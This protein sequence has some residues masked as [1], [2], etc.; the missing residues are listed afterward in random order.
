M[1]AR[2]FNASRR[3]TSS[4]SSRGSKSQKKINE[5]NSRNDNDYHSSNSSSDERDPTITVRM[6]STTSNISNQSKRSNARNEKRDNEIYDNNRKRKRTGSSKKGSESRKL[7]IMEKEL[8][9]SRRETRC[10]DTLRNYKRRKECQSSTSDE[11][12][13]E[14]DNETESE[15]SDGKLKSQFKNLE[16]D[17]NDWKTKY[18]ELKTEYDS[19]RKCLAT[20]DIYSDGKNIN[21]STKSLLEILVRN[22]MF[23]KQKFITQSELGN[24]SNKNSIGNKLMDEMNIPDSDRIETWKNYAYVVKKHLDKIRSSKTTGM[25]NEFV[26]RGKMQ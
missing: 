14:D 20:C 1:L 12:C 17:S 6:N 2:N 22:K 9:E 7:S 25:K 24:L 10:D 18:I 5:T 19:K 3:S 8:R 26:K 16:D 15:D 23:P 4:S 13:Y 11:D 21:K